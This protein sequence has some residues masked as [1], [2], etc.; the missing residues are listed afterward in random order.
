MRVMRLL[1]LGVLGVRPTRGQRH[2]QRAASWE[3]RARSLMWMRTVTRSALGAGN[4]LLL[5]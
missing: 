1:L 2:R 3:R 4:V 5:L